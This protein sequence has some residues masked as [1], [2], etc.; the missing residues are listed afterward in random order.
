MVEEYKNGDPKA[1][2]GNKKLTMTNVALTMVPCTSYPMNTGVVKYGKFNW[3]AQ[4]KNSMDPMVYM[5]GLMRHY[6]LWMA[7]Q[8]LTSDTGVNHIDAMM[9]G[10]SVLRDA[11]IFG[12]M[13]DNRIKLSPEDMEIYEQLINNQYQ[14]FPEF[15]PEGGEVYD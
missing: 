11:W 13:K 1:H 7:G 9:A 6:H 5:N 15:V 12:R 4:P 14:E 8:D 3:L 10:L 2:V